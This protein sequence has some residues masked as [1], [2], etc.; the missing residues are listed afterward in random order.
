MKIYVE[1]SK[2]SITLKGIGVDYQLTTKTALYLD[3]EK[4]I[5]EVGEAPSDTT[6]LSKI[7]GF[8]EDRLLIGDV[9]A[10]EEILKYVIY[11]YVKEAPHNFITDLIRPSVLVYINREFEGGIT[12]AEFRCLVDVFEQVG[13]NEVHILKEPLEGDLSKMKW[14]EA[15]RIHSK[16]PPFF[17]Y[18]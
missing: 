15:K 6:N 14:S 17:D 4:E 16:Q 9:D 13:A 3:K 8:G 12:K 5:V 1:I 11:K 2:G 7:D 18:L 10:V